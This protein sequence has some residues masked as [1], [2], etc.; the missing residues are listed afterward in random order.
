MTDPQR[1]APFLDDVATA[2][3]DHVCCGDH[4]SFFT[5]AG[6]DG[7]CRPGW[8]PRSTSSSPCTPASTSCRCATRSSLPASWPTSSV[9]GL[10]ACLRRWRR[11]RGPAR[12]GHLRRRPGHRGKRMDECLT[13]LRQLLS[14]APTTLRRLLRSRRSLIAPAPPSPTPIVIGGRSDTPSAALAARSTVARHLELAPA[15]RRRGRPR[16]ARGA[17][18]GRTDPPR[19]HACRSG[20]GWVEAGRRPGPRL[21]RRWNLLRRALRTGRALLAVRHRR[22]RGRAARSLC[23]GRLDLVQPDPQADSRTS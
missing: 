10:A 22:G 13:V 18:G 15:L 17:A 19:R 21:H 6:F 14:G 12:G 16:G 5:G 2:G 9:S 1:L 8:L 23:R 20:A 7:S 3:L 11:R 4:V